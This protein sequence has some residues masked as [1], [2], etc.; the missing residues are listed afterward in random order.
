MTYL[1]AAVA[2]LKAARTAM[3][4]EEITEA[5][6]RKGLIHLRGNAP[7][8]TVSTAL[9]WRL[10]DA[11]GPALSGP[12]ARRDEGDLWLCPA[13][14]CRPICIRRR[15]RAWGR[16]ASRSRHPVQDRQRLLRILPDVRP[17]DIAPERGTC[18]S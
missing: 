5:A 1:E 13:A 15:L 16:P 14:L 17:F 2:V 4:I 12:S 18:P 8:A 7:V 9:F 10:Q 3:S 11:G 6:I